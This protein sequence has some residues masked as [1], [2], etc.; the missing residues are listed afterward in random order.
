MSRHLWI[1]LLMSTL[2][3]SC[4][5]ERPGKS[6]EPNI[7]VILADDMGYGDPG[8]YNPSSKIPTPNIDRLAKQGMRF[9]DAHAAGTWCVPSRYGL[10]TGRYPMRTSLN[11]TEES[12]IDSGRTTIASLLKEEGYQTGMVGKWHQGFGNISALK[13]SGYT[14]DVEGGPADHG[15]DY[16]YGIPASLDIPPYFYIENNQVVEPPADSVAASQTPDATTSIQGAFWRAGKAAP[17]FEHGEVLPRFRDKA[18]SFVEESQRNEEGQPFFLYMALASPHTP[19]LP[20]EEFRGSSE[21]GMYGDFVVQTDSII[22]Q[23]MQKLDELKVKDN[24][25]VVF[26]SDNGPVWFAP[27][28][29]KFGHKATA[30]LRGMKTDAWEGGHRV[31]FIARWPGKINAGS[32]SNALIGFTDLLA[33]FGEIT[34]HQLAGTSQI[35]SES[36]LPILLGRKDS[37]RSSLLIEDGAVRKGPWKLIFDYGMGGVHRNYRP[38]SD[39]SIQEAEGE[40]YN[41]NNDRSEQNNLYEE[42]PAKVKELENL[43]EDTKN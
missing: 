20:S 14:I 22:G 35:D 38:A 34:G 25:L 28:R 18:I 12:V 43:F 7:V 24:T 33:T 30:E 21:A 13:E 2:C 26:T 40:L 36:M 39:S 1:L 17:N 31:P 27:D 42:N 23:I 15:F 6:A 37:V 9:T 3:I 19:W 32:I 11:W 29:E 41:L 16:Y 8:A 10:L 5:N 4:N